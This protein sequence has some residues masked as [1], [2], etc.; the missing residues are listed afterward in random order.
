MGLWGGICIAIGV[1]CFPFAVISYIWSDATYVFFVIYPF[2]NYA[3]PLV[4]IGLILIIIGVGIRKQ[5]RRE[6]D[7]SH[8]PS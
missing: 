5:E 4:F 8:K 7:Q 2:R 1:L 6:S 3:L